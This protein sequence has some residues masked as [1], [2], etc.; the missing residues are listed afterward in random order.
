MLPLNDVGETVYPCERMKL[1][2]SLLYTIKLIK[3]WV[4]G[5]N[6]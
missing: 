4:K 3:K 1:L 6:I 5:L 2:P